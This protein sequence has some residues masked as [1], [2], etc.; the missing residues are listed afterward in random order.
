MSPI[1]IE[2]SKWG[3]KV[4][5]GVTRFLPDIS[6]FPQDL[7]VLSLKIFP[8][9]AILRTTHWP[10]LV[11]LPSS[12][13]EFKDCSWPIIVT[14]WPVGNL[15]VET[16]AAFDQHPILGSSN[17]YR[18]GLDAGAHIMANQPDTQK[19]TNS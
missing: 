14:L 15:R 5:A 19:M 10:K 18:C 12:A 1:T 4:M 13:T 9:V 6:Y 16:Q 7:A 2:P 17:T 3:Q 8:R 11:V